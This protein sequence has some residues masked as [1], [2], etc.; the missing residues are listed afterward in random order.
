M[1]PAIRGPC[2]HRDWCLSSTKVSKE[3]KAWD[4]L[5]NGYRN[6]VTR[7]H[8]HAQLCRPGWRRLLGMVRSNENLLS[9]EV[10]RASQINDLDANA[11]L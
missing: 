4:G 11:M 6:W 5:T 1:M 3:P 7:V 8:D 9:F 10:I 2:L